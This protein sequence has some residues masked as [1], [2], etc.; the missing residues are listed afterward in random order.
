M[1]LL[2]AAGVCESPYSA[3]KQ[4]PRVRS[5]DVATSLWDLD[6]LFGVG[7]PAGGNA[8]VRVRGSAHRR[9]S[10]G[11]SKTNWAERR[12]S[13]TTKRS[14]RR[15]RRLKLRRLP[16]R[17]RLRRGLRRPRRRRRRRRMLQR[18]CRRRR[19]QRLRRRGRRRLVEVD[20]GTAYRTACKIIF[21]DRAAIH[22][23][24]IGLVGVSVIGTSL[25]QLVTTADQGVDLNEVQCGAGWHLRWR[26]AD[27]TSFHCMCSFG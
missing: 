4:T 21:A 9:A 27:R 8:S 6:T 7:F 1:P 17:R 20:S 14:S 15:R 3:P 18:R 5:S 12:R 22:T 24:R 2:L 10:R 16:R 26:Q 23:L 19:R 11:A 25:E 13:L